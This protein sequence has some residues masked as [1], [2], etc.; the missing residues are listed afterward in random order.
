MNSATAEQQPQMMGVRRMDGSLASKGP[1]LNGKKHGVWENFNPRGI[2]TSFETYHNGLK[3]GPSRHLDPTASFVQIESNYLYGVPHGTW[4]T[5]VKGGLIKKQV[6]Y[7][8]NK[9]DGPYFEDFS[10]SYM[11][12]EMKDSHR[13][14]VWEWYKKVDIFTPDILFKRIYYKDDGTCIRIVYYHDNGR[15]KEMT[16]GGDE[17]CHRNGTWAFWDQDGKITHI[18][19]FKHTSYPLG[20]AKYFNP[21]GSVR[22]EG[23]YDETGRIGVWRRY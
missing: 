19:E 22:E 5:Y 6:T 16:Q 21:D 3:H 9:E 12:G 7:N 15:M 18:Y 23:M 8:N 13:V 11:K 1:V 20:P 14:G 2:K 17:D 4:T 10:D